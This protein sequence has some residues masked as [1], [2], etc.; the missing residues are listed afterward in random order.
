MLPN[1]NSSL[2]L[3]P[4]PS[5]Q[6]IRTFL[7]KKLP[8]SNYYEFECS[9]SAVSVHIGLVYGIPFEFRWAALSC[10]ATPRQPVS[11]VR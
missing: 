7:L 2:A 5:N 4:V 10:S 3:F 1:S 11:R 6:N 8:N 9:K